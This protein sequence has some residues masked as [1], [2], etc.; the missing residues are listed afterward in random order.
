MN[1]VE[2]GIIIAILCAWL[3][4]DEL[5]R[6]RHA[7]ERERQYVILRDE[8]ETWSSERQQLLDRIQAS[9]FAE[10]KHAEIKLTKAQNG[11]REPPKLEVL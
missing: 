1:I 3:V 6:R 10:Y 5:Q 7:Y 9:S 8:R 4:S 11:E 2:I